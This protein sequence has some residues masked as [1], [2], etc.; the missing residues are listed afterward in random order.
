MPKP[1][2]LAKAQ[3]IEMESGLEIPAPGTQPVNVQFNPES[4]KVTYANQVVTDPNKGAQTGTNALQHVGKGTTKLAVQLWFDINHPSVGEANPR[5]VRELTAQVAYFITPKKD[6]KQKDSFTVPPIKFH[7]GAFSFVGMMESLE[8]TLELFSNDGRPLR[9]SLS[10]SLTQQEIIAFKKGQGMRLPAVAEATSSSAVGT[11][12]LTSAPAGSSLQGL[13][14][15]SGGVGLSWQDV[16]SANGI[17][18]PRLL[19][20]GQLLDLNASVRVEI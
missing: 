2:Q 16:A 13:A 10:F 6:P 20:S 15:I 17:E 12:P 9:A 5:D 4:L 18:N 14:D 1:V 19:A 7:W 8:E 3:L 11:T